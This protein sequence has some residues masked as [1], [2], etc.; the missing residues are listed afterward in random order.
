MIFERS[1]IRELAL[2]ALAS[3]GILLAIYLTQAF[4]R[5]LGRAAGG[6]IDPETVTV[7]LAFIT[8]STLPIVLTVALFF[9][10]LHVLT[11]SYRD[12]EMTI[13][14]ASG[15]SL[16]AWVRPVLAFALPV[17]V[18]VG[19][20]SLVIAPW[21]QLQLMEYQ[22][23]IEGRNDV[24]RVQP[25]VFTESRRSDKV[26]FVDRMSAGNDSVNNVFLQMIH[27]G[28]VAVVVAQRAYTELDSAGDT[29]L[30]LIN[31]RRYEG[32]PGGKDYR[33]VDF[34]RFAYRLEQRIVDRVE[35]RISALATAELWGSEARERVA[36]LHWR[37]AVPIAALLMALVAIPLSF[38]NPRQGRS[39]NFIFAI[40]IFT[41]YYNGLN[42]LQALTAKGQ[43]AAWVGLW[44][45]HGIMLVLLAALFWRRLKPLRW[46]AWGR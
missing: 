7:M 37:I 27:E 26:F 6:A 14:F 29:F 4:I 11:R 32:T 20:I 15:A 10:V 13:W 2:A 17:V 16:L 9:A 45:M 23:K 5:F 19:L 31:G 18:L 1:L 33:V 40:L 30:I 22:R 39:F 34:Q 21:S 42:T 36:E 8:M 25:G 28:R 46:V 44:P 35:P 41:V 24:T 3:A 43:I 38:V 12:S